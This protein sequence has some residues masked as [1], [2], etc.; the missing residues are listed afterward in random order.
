MANPDNKYMP[1]SN[2]NNIVVD[3]KT[4]AEEEKECST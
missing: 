1:K 4:D 2:D 3:V